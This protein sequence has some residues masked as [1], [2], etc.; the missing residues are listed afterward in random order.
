MK[1]KSIA[2]LLGLFS[3]ALPCAAQLVE[4]TIEPFVVHDGSIAELDGMTT[5]HVYAVCTNPEDEVSAVF[6]DASAPLTLTST[7]G[8]YQNTLGSNTGWTINPAFFGAFPA[9]EYDSWITI[10]VM[11]QD[12]VTGQ[13]NTVGLE[14]A[15]AL[16]DAGGD[17]VIDAEF[18]G[19]W[20]TI[21]G[22]AQAQAGDDLK[23]LLAQVTVSNDAVV[24]GNFGLQ[25][26][27]NGSQLNVENYDNIPFSSQEDAIFG[28]MDP[29]AVNYNPDA[30]E[31]G[32]TCIY[33]CALELALTSI[34]PPSCPYFADGEIQVSSTGS[35]LGVLYGMGQDPP[36]LAVGIFDGLHGGVYT[37][38]ALDGA[39]CEAT[40]EVDLVDPDPISISASLT[41]PVSCNGG[42]DAVISGS[43]SGGTGALS[44]SLSESFVESSADV[45]FTDLSPGLYT[46]YAMDENGC[47]A[48]SGAISVANPPALTVAVSGG[49]NGILGATCADSEDGFAVLITI[50]G[51]GPYTSMQ[52]SADGVNFTPENV[53]DDLSP[54]IY[55]FY[56]MDANG[57]IAATANEYEVYGPPSIDL[58]ILTEDALCFGEHGWVEVGAEGGNGDLSF[59][60]NEQVYEDTFQI[61]ILPGAY[62]VV[63]IDVEG[64]IAVESFTIEQPAPIEWVFDVLDEPSCSNGFVGFIELTV[65]G[66]VPPYIVQYN[67]F[68]QD[69]S[70][71]ATWTDGAG[72]TEFFITDANGCQAAGM[73]ELIGAPS[74]DGF[75]P[76]ITEPSCYGSSDASIALDPAFDYTEWDVSWTGPSSG[77]QSPFEWIDGLVAGVYSLSLSSDEYTD[78]EATVDIVI[79]DPLAVEVQLESAS[80]LCADEQSGI[81]QASVENAS[82]SVQWTLNGVAVSMQNSLSLFGLP[83]GTY[84]VSATD[85]VG[86]SGFETAILVNPGPIE[87]L[88]SS[89]AQP[90][91]FANGSIS[92]EVLPDYSVSWFNGDGLY[93]GMGS[94]LSDLEAGT[95]V[96]SIEDPSGCLGEQSFELEFAGC[97][98]VDAS[99]WPEGAAG[100]YP[101]GEENWYLGLE[102]SEE[103]VLRVPEVVVDAGVNFVVSHFEL[104]SVSNLPVGVSLDSAAENTAE[105]E[106][107]L[108]L[109]IAGTPTE[110]GSY[111]VIV[112]GTM[113]IVLF[114]TQFPIPN[115]AFAKTV[116][117]EV[118]E[119]PI[120][121]CT[122]DWASNFN[123]FA[124]SDDGSCEWVG[125]CTYDSA[126]NYDPQAGVDD[127]SCVFNFQPV[128]DGCYFDF[129]DNGDVGSADLLTFLSAYG[130]V[131][132]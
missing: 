48:V 16:F 76:I 17:F 25:L 106:S 65:F 124:T 63:A 112:S 4:V 47:T 34:T 28:C 111:E 70:F 126:E 59:E 88:P 91:S 27:V 58:S 46:I 9:T 33:P 61:D 44:Y 74:F 73:Y 36:S 119:N 117:V 118:P 89:V 96:A 57:C 54:G 10:G 8:F 107:V 83:A 113:Y 90:T 53:L 50:G 22:D 45:N 64:C 86:C 97:D 120:Q 15:F 103:W 37:F 14:D 38:T 3:C 114:G 2:A 26:F 84:E 122:Y 80:P 130:S 99:D 72:E 87:D 18:G 108:C 1:A 40:I 121:G 20:F 125:G 6:G 116:L 43:S 77:E 51:S 105:A 62:E 30:T 49:Q 101:E 95:Y 5:Y 11:N 100:L 56:A 69:F 81:V 42:S 66:G 128:E 131:C 75:E 85:E 31:S 32:E 129:D 39:G 92:L 68:D 52:Y 115:Y 71:S 78:C 109:P 35:Q 79:E 41:V 94:S 55:T 21:F 110:A 23:V 60:L 67:G 102:N 82:G 93:V 104:D 19:S 98:L 127:G 29:D 12:E 132:E 24:T 7:D 123:P 13:P